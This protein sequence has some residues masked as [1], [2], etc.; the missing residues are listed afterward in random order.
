MST[1]FA[2]VGSLNLPGD[3]GL[4]PDQIP[5]N[6]SSAFDSEASAVLNLTGAGTKA[7]SLG[8]I[9]SPGIKGLLI[10]MD[11]SSTAAPVLVQV[12]S[13]A[14]GRL[15]LAPGGFLL[16]GNPAPAAGVTDLDIV[17]TT[18]CVVRIWALG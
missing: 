16:Y 13:S 5:V 1:P 9:A 3:S 2:I 17:Y 10:K 15:E 8:S 18:P 7:V 12:N 4:P 11:P 14:T 6:F